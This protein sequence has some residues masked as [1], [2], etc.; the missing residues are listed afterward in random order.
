[1]NGTKVTLH[2]VPLVQGMKMPLFSVRAA[3]LAGFTTEFSDIGVIIRQA[4]NTIL[5]GTTSGGI[6]A[7]HAQRG[8]RRAKALAASAA[9]PSPPQPTATRADVAAA[10]P[11]A[12]PE[13]APTPPTGG[14]TEAPKS[15]PTTTPKPSGGQG[16]AAAPQPRGGVDVK[17]A[18]WHH[19]YGH[20]SVDGLIRTLT[21]VD[22][23]D[24]TRSSL[25]TVKGAP[26][27]PC[28]MGKMV[29]A[30]YL[31]SD[32]KPVRVLM[33]VHS[34]L[35]GPMS[36]PTTKGRRYMLGVV[37]DYIRFK[38]L[39]PIM[40]KGQ[41]KDA[42]VHVLNLW[43]NSTEKLVGTIRSNDGKEYCGPEFDQWMSSKGIKHETS[44]PYAHQHKG[45][46]ERFKRTVQEHMLAV[47]TE[48]RLDHKYWGEAAT[49][50]SGR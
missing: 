15:S 50:V 27:E 36:V 41:A 13:E 18:L 24:L 19:R 2:D 28:I 43:E 11:P 16:T 5:Q 42:L 23:M 34:D 32:R 22:G 30:P 45:V 3:S 25:A 35:I 1:M 20:L 39:V 8:G 17:A 37:D 9:T 12:D 33:L 21:A 48:A 31:A 14:P 49:A 44:A 10:A 38:V 40:D 29:R 6:Y 4:G 46:A 47:L 26:C 7:L